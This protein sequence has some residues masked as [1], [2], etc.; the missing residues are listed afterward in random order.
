VPLSQVS[1]P[2]Q[3]YR[4]GFHFASFDF[5]NPKRNSYRYMLQGY[6][7]DWQTLQDG[8]VASYTNLTPGNYTLKM[9]ASNNQRHFNDSVST[10]NVEVLPYWWQRITVQFFAVL[11]LVLLVS[12]LVKRRINQVHKMN[13]LLQQ[14][15]QQKNLRQAELE[16]AVAERTAE[17]QL[18]LEQQKQ[19]YDELQHL[20]LLKD[21]FISTVSHELRTP[22]TSISGALQLVLSGAISEDKAKMQHL[23]QI[24]SSNSKRLTLLINDLL[25]LEKLAANKM[26]FE[27]LAQP[28]HP[29]IQRAVAENSTYSQERRVKLQYQAADECLSA[30]AQVDEHRLLQVLANVLSNA[31]KFSPQDGL[32]RVQ[33]YSEGQKLIISIADEGPGIAPEFQPRIFQRFSQANSG[34]TR[35]QGGT[36]LGL[37]LSQELMRAM[38]GDITFSSPPGEGCTFYLH[39]AL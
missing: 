5:N 25:D 21:Q 36:G 12:W 20:D 11:L 29:I 15:M 13:E 34:N 8:N 19:A 39:F 14:A 30:I 35:Q 27:L 26:H 4:V 33:L 17:L 10:L 18:S 2:P 24:A 16:N 28:L 3:V 9:V 1:I 6:D 22:L 7:T 37:A 38:H 32:V 23:L 31:I